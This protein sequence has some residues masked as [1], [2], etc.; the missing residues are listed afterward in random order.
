MTR[1]QVVSAHY[2]H[3]R[4][5]R[6]RAALIVLASFLLGRSLRRRRC[7]LHLLQHQSFQRCRVLRE[8]CFRRP[9]RRERRRSRRRLFFFY[10][11]NFFVFVFVF[12]F[13]FF[14][15]PLEKQQNLRIVQ[16]RQTSRAIFLRVQ[17]SHELF[18]VRESSLFSLLRA[19]SRFVVSTFIA[20]FKVALSLRGG[21]KWKRVRCV[22]KAVGKEGIT[23]TGGF[24][25]R[26]RRAKRHLVVRRTVRRS[27]GLAR[28]V[29]VRLCLCFV[30]ARVFILKFCHIIN[31]NCKQ[32]FRDTSPR[33]LSPPTLSRS[34]RSKSRRYRSPTRCPRTRFV[35]SSCKR[36]DIQFRA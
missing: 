7:L 25:E 20:S 28:I 32:N 2:F 31:N 35:S 18:V 26:R 9:Q 23:M 14:S 33:A 36:L 22:V 30:R 21:Q 11:R 8:L 27:E 12:V 15:F 6:R 17:T 16:R 5:A 4:D 19:S 24:R 10:Y 3:G 29:C 34:E 1:E 13:V